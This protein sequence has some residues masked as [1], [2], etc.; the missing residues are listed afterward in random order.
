MRPHL[1][2]IGG[3]LAAFSTWRAAL[4]ARRGTILN[5][6]AAYLCVPMGGLAAVAIAWG[7]P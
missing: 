3:T 6:I 7:A 1:I 4:A 5:R 2:F